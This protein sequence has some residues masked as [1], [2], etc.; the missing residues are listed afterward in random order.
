MQLIN[1]QELVGDCKQILA[2]K[3]LI[4]MRSL[5]ILLVV[6]VDLAVLCHDLSEYCLSCLELF[7]EMGAEVVLPLQKDES[8]LG[9][10]ISPLEK[11]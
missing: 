4:N 11:K 3:F 8:I 2:L 9:F 10:A 7:Y 1:Q 5:K 6:I